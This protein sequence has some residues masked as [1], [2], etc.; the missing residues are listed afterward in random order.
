MHVRLSKAQ[1]NLP[2]GRLVCDAL[3]LISKSQYLCLSSHRIEE[4]MLVFKI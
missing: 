3:V 2:A 4:T 1:A